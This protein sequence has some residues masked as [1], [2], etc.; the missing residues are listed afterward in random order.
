MRLTNGTPIGSK[1]KQI[2]PDELIFEKS[3]SWLNIVDKSEE[4]I[5]DLRSGWQGV[6]E[7]IARQ[8]SQAALSLLNEVPWGEFIR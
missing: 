1:T 5:E 6:M 8:N 4:N 7:A 2:L 3:I